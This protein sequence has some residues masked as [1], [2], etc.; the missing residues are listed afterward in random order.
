MVEFKDGVGKYSV[1]IDNNKCQTIAYGKLTPSQLAMVIVKLLHLVDVLSKQ[2]N[3][4]HDFLID[5]N[6]ELSTEKEPAPR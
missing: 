5:N 3:S 4:N 1:E 2:L 6:Y